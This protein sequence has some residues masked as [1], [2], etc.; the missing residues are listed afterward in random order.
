M[1]ATFSKVYGKILIGFCIN[2][3]KRFFL[4]ASF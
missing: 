1:V 2:T 3:R 4:E